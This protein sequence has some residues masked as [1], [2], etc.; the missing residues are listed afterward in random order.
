VWATETCSF[1]GSRHEGA[2]AASAQRVVSREPQGARG[3]RG[4]PSRRV[5]ELLA[6]VRPFLEGEPPVRR[7]QGE[8]AFARVEV[9]EGKEA[10]S[11]RAAVR[12]VA[13]GEDG[14]LRVAVSLRTAEAP[15]RVRLANLVRALGAS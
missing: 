6:R 4:R 13:A 1:A 12:A 5:A 7:W 15:P 8:F 3:S 10:E 2:P 9:A 14:E 11:V